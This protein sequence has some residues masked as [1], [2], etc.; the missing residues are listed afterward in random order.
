MEM[1]TRGNPFFTR[2]TRL[3]PA[4]FNLRRLCRLA[5]GYDLPVDDHTRIPLLG[6]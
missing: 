4:G 3:N 5:G 1:L 6:E 2:P